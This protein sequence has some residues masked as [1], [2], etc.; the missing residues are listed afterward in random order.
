MN[1]NKEKILYIDPLSLSGH[2]NFNNIQIKSLYKVFDSIDFTFREGYE[3]NLSIKENETIFLI[4]EKLYKSTNNKIVNRI[5]LLKIFLYIKKRINLSIYDF[6]ILSSYEEISLYFSFIKYPLILVN[7]NNIADLNNPIKR[8]FFKKVAKNN[9]N[10]VFG[11]YIKDYLIRIGVQN[12]EVINHGLPI[13]IDN[14]I[15][16]RSVSNQFGY[17]E[18]FKWIIFSASSSSSDKD[19]IDKIISNESLQSY[20]NK[21]NILFILKGKYTNHSQSNNIRIIDD[22]LANEEYQYLFLRSNIIL[23]CYPSS[24]KYQVSAILFECDQ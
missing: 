10:L 8:F 16:K 11:H 18:N 3:K 14:K 23:I 5:N 13:P 22:Y 12:I 20:L 17:T 21:K 2:I 6:I 15:L 24:F 19:F 1:I 4:P 9:T 7:H